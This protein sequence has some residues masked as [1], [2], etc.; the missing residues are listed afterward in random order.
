MLEEASIS[1]SWNSPPVAELPTRGI[2]GVA[3]FEVAADRLPM[4]DLEVLD[5]EAHPV[6]DVVG[7]L[8]KLDDDGKPVQDAAPGEP[9]P[10]RPTTRPAGHALLS[11]ARAR[12]PRPSALLLAARNRTPLAWPRATRVQARQCG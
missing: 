1:E 9:Q 3:V 11:R 7:S 12:E 10:I 4:R 2:S 6:I 8:T 5:D